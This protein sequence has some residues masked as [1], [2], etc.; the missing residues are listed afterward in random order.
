MVE[1]K[2][3]GASKDTAKD[4]SEE[5]VKVA[6]YYIWQK[7]GCP[8]GHDI[9]H[10]NLAKSELASMSQSRTKSAKP[11]R[12]LPTLKRKTPTALKRRPSLNP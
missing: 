6:A 7:E 4:I 10:W 9:K 1:K 5:W 2:V 11:R 8:F 12:E 3:I